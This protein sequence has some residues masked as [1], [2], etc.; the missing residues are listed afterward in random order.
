MGT[1]VNDPRCRRCGWQREALRHYEGPLNA[2]F[3]HAFDYPEKPE[4]T[5]TFTLDALE[6]WATEELSSWHWS[7]NEGLLRQDRRDLARYA[8][9]LREAHAE[10]VA[11]FNAGY[12]AMKAGQPCDAEPAGT[13]YDVWHNGWAWAAHDCNAAA[14]IAALEAERAQLVAQFEN[15]GD[16]RD[17]FEECN[18]GASEAILGGQKEGGQ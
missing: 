7:G 10:E 16:C 15:C 14:R 9:A 12:E 18:P 3:D 2:D 1:T 17:C 6:R 13:K 4:S 8:L 11:E 5:P